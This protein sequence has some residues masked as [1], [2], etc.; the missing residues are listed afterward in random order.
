MT[1]TC[2]YA[3]LAASLLVS[4]QPVARAGESFPDREL[5]SFIETFLQWY[6]LPGLSVAVVQHDELAYAR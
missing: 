1:R 5:D 6:A 3:L 4:F 2:R